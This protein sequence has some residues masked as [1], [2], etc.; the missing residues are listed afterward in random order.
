[1]KDIVRL[2]RDCHSYRHHQCRRVIYVKRHPLAASK[3]RA[4]GAERSNWRELATDL[5]VPCTCLEII[6]TTTSGP[7]GTLNR[8]PRNQ[9]R[10][11]G[12]EN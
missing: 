2:H 6:I 7:N 1:M 3:R 10:R 4:W 5:T 11:R 12:A 9:D 8:Y